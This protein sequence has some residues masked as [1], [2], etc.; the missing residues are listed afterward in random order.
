MTA[1]VSILNLAIGLSGVKLKTQQ[2]GELEMCGRLGQLLE[3]DPE[4]VKI[5]K[6]KFGMKDEDLKLAQAMKPKKEGPV[7][8]APQAGLEEEKGMEENRQALI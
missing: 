6:E 3:K 4:L 8:D 5:A 1:S 7:Q 2:K